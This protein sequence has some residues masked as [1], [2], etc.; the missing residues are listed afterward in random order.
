M[1]V[2]AEPRLADFTTLGLGGPARRFV[3]AATRDAV[4]AAVDAADADGEPLLVMA[5]G[6]NLVVADEGFDGTVVRVATRGIGMEEHGDVVNLTIAAGEPWDSVVE[7]CV[8]DGLAGV[9]CLSGIPGSAG[10]TPVQNVGAYG[11]E[12]ADTMVSLRAYDRHERAV[13]EL[14]AADCGFA[15]RTSALRHRDRYVVLGVTLELDR[16]RVGRPL[17]HLELARS[18][19]VELGGRAPL[20]D[21]RE[22][23]LA[24]RRRKGMVLDPGDPDSRSAGSFFLNPILSRDRFVALD[25]RVG[26]R[27]GGDVHA[28]AW[29]AGDEHVKTSAAWLIERAGFTRGY[30]KRRAGV[31]SKH[32]LA[33]VNRDGATTA[34]L[35]EVARELRDGVESAFGVRLEPEP[36][37]VG[38]EL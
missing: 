29:P 9:E 16:S 28:P 37:L 6:S 24:L 35:L 30:G 5:G 25:Q 31:S 38:V 1:E 23:V 13:V 3:D 11:E 4:I 2:R 22:A 21:V 18:L 19:G 32:T 36:T 12:I 20:A 33:L 26:E 27:F 8:A 7:R 17:H 14:S 10:A 34:E 15:Y